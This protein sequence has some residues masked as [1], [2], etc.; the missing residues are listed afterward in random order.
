MAAERRCLGGDRTIDNEA[1]TT[2][3]MLIPK[4]VDFNSSIAFFRGSASTGDLSQL[5]DESCFFGLRNKDQ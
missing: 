5:I 3:T 1:R 2:S 4:R